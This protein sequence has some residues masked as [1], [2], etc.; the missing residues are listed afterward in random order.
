MNQIAL[1]KFEVDK[2]WAIVGKRGVGKTTVALKDLAKLMNKPA[3]LYTHTEDYVSFK[4]YY[5]IEFNRLKQLNSVP[6]IITRLNDSLLEDEKD[7]DRFNI[8]MK[9]I[10]RDLFNYT[11][12]FDDAGSIFSAI[13]TKSFL[14][15]LANVRHK[16]YTIILI[17]HSLNEI[18]LYTLPH[19]DFIALFKTNDRVAKSRLDRFP[20]S[21]NVGNIMQEVNL[22]PD[23]RFF[24]IIKL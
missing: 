6:G 1:N 18:P 8:I 19:L 5:T 17:F 11:L 12:I 4:D 7:A 16:K 2:V 23:E 22:H 20:T 3:L 15:L 21:S 24:K 9:Y 13:R 14:K 10:Y